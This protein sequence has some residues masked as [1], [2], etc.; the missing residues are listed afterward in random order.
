MGLRCDS[1]KDPGDGRSTNIL[2]LIVPAH[3]ALCFTERRSPQ[4]AEWGRG[5]I[6]KPKNKNKSCMWS[7]DLT[8]SEIVVSKAVARSMSR[9][10]EQ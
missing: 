1:E 4:D 3:R 6:S 2:F 10:D 8:Q 5:L 9:H 7:N